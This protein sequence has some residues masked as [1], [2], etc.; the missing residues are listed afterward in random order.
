MQSLVVREAS[1][2]SVGPLLVGEPGE[3]TQAG[4]WVLVEEGEVDPSFASELVMVLR[5]L[6]ISNCLKG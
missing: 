3:L 4:K 2:E 6:G 5:S 1:A